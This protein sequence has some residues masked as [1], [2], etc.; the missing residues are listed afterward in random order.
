MADITSTIASETLT[1]LGGPATVQVSL[2]VGPKGD[3]GN[4][5]FYGQGKPTVVSLPQTAKV[6]D[7]YV[8]LLQSD[9]EYKMV[10]QYIY[11]PGGPRWTQVF[12]LEPD[13]FRKQLIGQNFDNGESWVYIPIVQVLGDSDGRAV[14]AQNFHIQCTFKSTNPIASSVMVSEVTLDI[15]NML[16]LPILIKAAEFDGDSWSKVDG[17]KDVYLTISVI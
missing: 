12:K 6:Y 8:N 1:I 2:D 10:Y 7:M 3:R 17:E 16:A 15:N 5:F 11:A 14:N 9:D 4:I 13:V